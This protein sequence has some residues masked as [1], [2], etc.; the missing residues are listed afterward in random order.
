MMT[1][2]EANEVQLSEVHRLL[3]VARH[4]CPEGYTITLQSPAEPRRAR[5]SAVELLQQVELSKERP[6]DPNTCRE[7]IAEVMQWRDGRRH[8]L[9][10]KPDLLAALKHI[11][12]HGYVTSDDR[13]MVC[14]AIA[15]AEGAS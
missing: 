10:P 11:D 13:N 9:E 1:S 2:T 6:I 14:A 12:A 5:D 7:V 15:K 4:L 8:A 3:D